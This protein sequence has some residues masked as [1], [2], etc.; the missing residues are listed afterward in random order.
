MRQ[1]FNFIAG[2]AL[3]LALSGCA[4]LLTQSPGRGLSPVNAV[5]DGG[6]EHLILF[7]HDVVSY[8]TEG[9]HQRGLPAIKSVYKGVT[10]RFASPEHKALF[11]QSPER[12]LPQ[13]N[14]YCAN[15]MVY[16]IPWGGDADTWKMI[17]GKLYIFGGAGSRDAFL[18]DVPRN[19]AL[20]HRYWNQEV[21]GSNAFVQRAWRL[22]VRVPHYKS[23]A[24]L[25]E[26]VAKA[27]R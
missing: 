9:T 21:N 18:L 14:G 20:A 23:G 19:M 15:G 4:P 8:F 16:G 5:S 27:K 7:G 25:A 10:F 22:V 2:A 24:Q 3:L 13:F 6:D 12:Y 17:D 1:F 11:D 26:E